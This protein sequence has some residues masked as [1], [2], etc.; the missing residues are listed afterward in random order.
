MIYPA[1]PQSPEELK[2]MKEDIQSLKEEQEIL[3]KELEI[4]KKH[5]VR[6]QVQEFKGAAIDVTVLV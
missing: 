4:I 3:Q 2:T 5:L 6:P 1:F